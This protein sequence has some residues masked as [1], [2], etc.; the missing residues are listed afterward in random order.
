MT[1]QSVISAR[2]DAE[3]LA[4]VDQIAME[5]G[6]SR[7]WFVAQAVRNAAEQESRFTAFVQQGRDD[8][9]S[10]NVVEHAEVMAM[11]DNMIAGHA[12]RCRE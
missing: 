12:T 3:T 7:A 1:K 11:M 4:L 5:Q 6:R 10:G 9:A 8:I 2:I